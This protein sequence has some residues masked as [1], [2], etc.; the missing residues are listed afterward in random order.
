MPF[1]KLLTDHLA[2]AVLDNIGPCSTRGQ[3]CPAWPLRLA[4]K[5]LM[6]FFYHSSCKPKLTRCW[7]QASRLIVPFWVL[8]IIS[9]IRKALIVSSQNFT[10]KAFWLLF[11]I[12][13]Q[14]NMTSWSRSLAT[15]CTQKIKITRCRHFDSPVFHNQVSM[16]KF[17]F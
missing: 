8:Q 12:W 16:K 6:I 4:R 5:R 1:N 15:D 2:G 10:S 3:Y 13:Y 9:R 7:I 14:V 17:E 11:C